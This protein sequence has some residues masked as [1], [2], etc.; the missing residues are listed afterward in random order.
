MFVIVITGS[1]YMKNEDLRIIKTKKALCNSLLDLMKEKTFEEIKVSDICNKALINRST[2]YAHFEDK[3]D[4]FSFYIEDLKT[5]LTEELKKNNSIKSP[6]DYYMGLIKILLDHI[7]EK[8]ESYLAIIINNRNSIVTDILYDTIDKDIIYNLNKINDNKKDIP[9]KI[10]AS[11]YLGAALSV[12][13]TWLKNL[14]KYKK[15]DIINYLSKLIPD[16]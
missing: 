15:E 13:I 10:I 11:F 9:N 14:N 6:K 16:D 2:F 12:G 4:L 1:D 5:S 3:Y 8:K 7:E